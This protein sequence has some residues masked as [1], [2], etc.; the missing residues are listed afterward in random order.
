M[1]ALDRCEFKSTNS[2][3]E[4]YVIINKKGYA[5]LPVICNKYF[6]LVTSPLNKRRQ[7]VVC[8]WCDS[9]GHSQRGTGN[10][11]FGK[12][13]IMNENKAYTPG[14]LLQRSALII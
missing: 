1:R 8:L 2:R 6:L 13:C 10:K 12:V 5:F 3:K 4:V 14:R 7:I 11:F 9:K